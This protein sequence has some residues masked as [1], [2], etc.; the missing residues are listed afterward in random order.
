MTQ[1]PRS[2]ILHVTSGSVTGKGDYEKTF[3]DL[4]LFYPVT[5]AMLVSGAATGAQSLGNME[6]VCRGAAVMKVSGI[7][8]AAA[9]LLDC[10]HL[11]ADSQLARFAHIPSGRVCV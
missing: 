4:P 8:P 7:D 9:Q 3:A 11:T 5:H 1:G 2:N 10:Y 6:G